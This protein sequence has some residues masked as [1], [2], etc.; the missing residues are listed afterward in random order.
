MRG[1]L[2]TAGIGSIIYR[3]IPAHAGN[4]SSPKAPNSRPPV[5]PRACGERLS[6][7]IPLSLNPGSSPRMRGTH[8]AH[9]P[10]MRGF[11]FIPAHA[12]NA[13][14]RQ[15]AA[16]FSPVHPRACGERVLASSKLIVVSCSSPRMRGTPSAPKSRISGRRFIPRMRGTRPRRIRHHYR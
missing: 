12:G 15:A 5:H 2:V 1:T 11:R 16:F 3:F 6:P 8:Q 14:G 9:D 13:L 7:L 4:A 10:A